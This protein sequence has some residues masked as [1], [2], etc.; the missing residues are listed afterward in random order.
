M[1]DFTHKLNKGNIESSIKLYQSK[2]IDI[3]L[4][5]ESNNI[6]DLLKKLKREK[7]KSGPYPNLTVFEASNRIMTDL[8]IL[9]GVKKLLN[10]VFKE[11]NFKEYN[12][13][14]G[15]ENLHDND[16]EAESNGVKLKGE[17]FNVAESHFP[18]KKCKMVNKL[19]KDYN[20]KDV[21][22]IIYNEDARKKKEV[23]R[24]E[25]NV[26]FLPVEIPL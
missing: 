20:G 11:I 24:K 16:I 26:Y 19:I 21:I 13:E 4:K 3:P 15:N 9:F 6:V 18:G 10:N 7:I 25:G 14:Y 17:A 2:L 23:P 22:I 1:K 5:I 12:V 8:V